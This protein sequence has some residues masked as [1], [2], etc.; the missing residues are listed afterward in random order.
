[1]S[2][3]ESDGEGEFDGD[4]NEVSDY[5]DEGQGH[6]KPSDGEEIGGEIYCYFFKE[7][8]YLKTGVKSLLSGIPVVGPD[9]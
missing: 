9:I 7:L 1:M 2:I 6:L 8:A 4:E 5:V 3:S